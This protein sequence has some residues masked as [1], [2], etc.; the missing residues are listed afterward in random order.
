[1]ARRL[2]GRG[3]RIVERNARVAG[4][5]GELDIV[6]LEAG[7][8]AFVEVKTLA[9]ASVRGPERPALAVGPRKQRQLRRLAAAY[10]A[11]RDLPP[12]T[13]I[14]FDVAGLRVD[15]AGRVVEWEYLRAAF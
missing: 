13:R 14:R 12:F 2:A 5:R 4:L 7:T 15:A 9:A 1:V 11:E 3:A 10:L 8:L 6:A